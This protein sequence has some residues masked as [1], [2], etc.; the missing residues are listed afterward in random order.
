MIETFL[1][2][3]F[4][5]ELENYGEPSSD[6]LETLL[7]SNSIIAVICSRIIFVTF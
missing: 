3:L 6:S 2:K 1:N 7:A 5:A 4:K